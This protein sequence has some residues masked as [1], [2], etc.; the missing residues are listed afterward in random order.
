MA[1]S[2]VSSTTREKG[3]RPRKGLGSDFYA[4]GSTKT[5]L[6][7]LSSTEIRKNHSQISTNFDEFL[8]FSARFGP[9]RGPQTGPAVFRT[10]SPR[11]RLLRAFRAFQHE[12]P[13]RRLVFLGQ[14]LALQLIVADHVDGLAFCQ[15]LALFSILVRIPVN[16]VG[17]LEHRAAQQYRPRLDQD[18]VV[19]AGGRFVAA[20]YVDH[21]QNASVIGLETAVREADG[22]QQF[23]TAQLKPDQ[24]VGVVDDA[25]LI[26]LGVAEAGFCGNWHSCSRFYMRYAGSQRRIRAAAASDP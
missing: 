26:G 6:T 7:L 5:I 23:H 21:R 1:G 15:E 20:G 3:K 4:P 17:K 16:L 8:P 12:S 13:Q 9:K 19:V 14:W 25:H 11:D 10:G 24:V 22:A 18:L 2:A